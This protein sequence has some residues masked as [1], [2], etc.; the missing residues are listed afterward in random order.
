MLT[1]AVSAPA[2]AL[3]CPPPGYE[4]NRDCGYQCG[5]GFCCGNPIYYGTYIF[6]TWRPDPYC[7]R[8][9][10]TGARKGAKRQ[11]KRSG[12]ARRKR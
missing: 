7:A 3:E 6:G 10:R 8:R 12:K 4:G 2:R 1:V 9:E 5:D 11:R